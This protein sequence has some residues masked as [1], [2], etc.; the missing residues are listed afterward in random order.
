MKVLLA[1]YNV[2]SEVLDEMKR[3]AAVPPDILK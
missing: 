2:D 3:R 1:G